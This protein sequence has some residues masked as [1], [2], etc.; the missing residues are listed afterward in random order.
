MCLYLQAIT[1]GCGEIGRPVLGR[2]SM[3][4]AG[5]HAKVTA[6]VKGCF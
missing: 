5:R 1:S 6:L 2:Q 4:S 3:P